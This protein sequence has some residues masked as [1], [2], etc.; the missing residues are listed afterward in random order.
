MLRRQALHA[1]H[2]A[3]GQILMA[4]V[5]IVAAQDAVGERHEFSVSEVDGDRFILFC[6]GEGVP[7]LASTSPHGPH[8]PERLQLCRSVVDLFGYGK[9]S[10]ER[11]LH[12]VGVV[13][14]IPNGVS[15][16]DMKP[17]LSGENDT[18]S[19]VQTCQGALQ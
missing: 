1:F 17:R 7:V 16:R 14:R 11:T 6:D 8:S 3:A 18:G 13:Q 2:E 15:E 12:Q 10:C 5:M 9:R 19:L 4:E